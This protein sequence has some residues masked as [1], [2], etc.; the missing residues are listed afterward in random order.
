MPSIKDKV[1]IIIG[2]TS[3]MGLASAKLFAEEGARVLVTGHSKD[4]LADATRDLGGDVTQ[5]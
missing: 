4:A 3:G 5:S 1:V 2:G